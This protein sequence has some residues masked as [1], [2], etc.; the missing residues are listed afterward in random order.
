M[1]IYKQYQNQKEKEKENQNQKEEDADALTPLLDP[2]N[3]PLMEKIR[4]LLPTHIIIKELY[5][6]ITKY[7]KYV[8]RWYRLKEYMPTKGIVNAAIHMFHHFVLINNTLLSLTEAQKYLLTSHALCMKYWIDVRADM[9]YITFMTRSVSQIV[10]KNEFI[11]AEIDMLFVLDL[12][13]R[14]YTEIMLQ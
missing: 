6:W 2:L 14:R 9:E 11:D 10:S 4:H 8:I 3:H 12:N 1:N 5:E 7:D 13:I